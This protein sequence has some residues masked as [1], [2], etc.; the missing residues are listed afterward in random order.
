MVFTLSL[1]HFCINL[2]DVKIFIKYSYSFLSILSNYHPELFVDLKSSMKT[3]TLFQ[4]AKPPKL[5]FYFVQKTRTLLHG[6]ETIFKKQKHL[7][8]QKMI[9]NIF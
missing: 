9:K 8:K 3:P 4:A 2:G 6:K 1:L 5:T 7:T